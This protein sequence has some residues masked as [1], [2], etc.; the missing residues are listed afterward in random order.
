MQAQASYLGT[1]YPIISSANKL[2]NNV[3][4]IIG[5]ATSME[6]L[7]A[8]VFLLQQLLRRKASDDGTN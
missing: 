6:R 3:A 2:N 5:S 8:A 1:K 7:L 4:S